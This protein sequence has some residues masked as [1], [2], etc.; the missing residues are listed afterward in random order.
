MLTDVLDWMYFSP[1]NWCASPKQGDMK[2]KCRLCQ[3]RCREKKI[4][5]EYEP[6]LRHFICIIYHHD[7]HQNTI[8][9][10]CLTI[11][12][13]SISQVKGHLAHYWWISAKDGEFPWSYLLF[14]YAGSSLRIPFQVYLWNCD[15]FHDKNWFDRDIHPSQGGKTMSLTS[16]SGC[17][18]PWRLV[19]TQI[20]YDRVKRMK[21]WRT[22][23]QKEKDQEAFDISTAVPRW[24]PEGDDQEGTHISGDE[25][26][27]GG[28]KLCWCVH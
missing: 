14:I 9:E 21:T 12:I 13:V 23:G 8:Q 1:Y 19:N 28:G 4:F 15:T 24:E 26:Q 11:V 27:G 2:Q 3:R 20:K 25:P 5:S 6:L 10:L 22:R 16:M 17:F 18:K 7:F